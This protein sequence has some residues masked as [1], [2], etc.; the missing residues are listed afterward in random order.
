MHFGLALS[1]GHDSDAE[2]LDLDFRH[3]VNVSELPALLSPLLPAGVEVTAAAEVS[4]SDA[5]LQAAVDVVIWRVAFDHLDPADV[6]RAAAGLMAQETLVVPLVR[7]GSTIQAD[8]RPALLRLAAEP[9]VPHGATLWAELATRPRAIRPGEL[10]SLLELSETP[11]LVTRHAQLMTID[12]QLVAPIELT[13]RP[14][15]PPQRLAS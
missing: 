11:R 10:L 15:A 2:Y 14:D 12:G 3:E 13:T 8:V 4:R 9:A 7:K 6:A 1:V 5:A